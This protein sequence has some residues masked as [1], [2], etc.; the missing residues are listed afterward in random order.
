MKQYLLKI[1]S[2][3]LVAALST[4]LTLYMTPNGGKLSELETLIEDRFIADTETK[5]LEDAAAAAMVKA[6]GDRW[7]Y[8]MSAEDYKSYL[9]RVDNSYVGI[10]ITIQLEEEE[11]YRILE[12]VSGG[13]ANQAGIEVGDL[14]FEVESQDIREMDVN[15]VRDL[16]TG[17][18][19]T[20][21]TLRV[22]R[23]GEPLSFSVERRKVETPVAVGEMLE[24]NVGL[25]TIEN[26]DSRCAEETIAAIESLLEQGAEALIFDVRNNPGGYA[27]ELV[28]LLDYLL[29]EGDLFR[30]VRYDRKEHTDT[31]DK[32]FLDI[33][34]VVL[35]NKDSYSAAEFFAAALKE[36]DAAVIV[37][38]QTVGKGYFQTTYP[39]SDGSAVALSIGKYY[40]PKGVNLS[41]AGGL[42][43]DV[44]IDLDE[45][46]HA[47]VYYNTLPRDQ[48]PHIQAALEKLK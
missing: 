21:V 47:A 35:V 7:S 9:D 17:K 4:A 5:V 26:F 39:L 48:D 31:S 25:I 12:V 43:P 37:G 11:G 2:Y 34:M 27:D 40:T 3:I 46:T 16:V 32:D 23:K 45:E 15:A 33:P 6:T 8:Y 22:L 13:P 38:E 28:T 14:L 24:K 41:E 18:S 44:R 36:Y 30:T 42:T 1:A 29:P 19:G 20:Y 10:G